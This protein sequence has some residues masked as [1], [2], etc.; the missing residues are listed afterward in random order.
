MGWCT[1]KDTEVEQ[2]WAAAGL[3]I[4]SASAPGLVSAVPT[5]HLQH[6]G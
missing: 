6:P 4:A 1:G 2:G 5:G 3:S